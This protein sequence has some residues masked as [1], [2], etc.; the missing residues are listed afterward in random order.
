VPER[1]RETAEQF[2]QSRRVV[3]DQQTHGLR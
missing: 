1:S 2:A 3:G